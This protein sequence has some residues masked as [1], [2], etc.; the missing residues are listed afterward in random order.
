[1]ADPIIKSYF[2]KSYFYTSSNI[3]DA[4]PIYLNTNYGGIELIL[5]SNQSG[6]DNNYVDNINIS[7]NNNSL[8]IS[9]YKF[10][11]TKL[12]IIDLMGHLLY[13][14]NHDFINP[15]I[16]DIENIPNS[17]L[18]YLILENYDGQIETYS[19]ILSK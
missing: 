17:F 13:Q 14:T 6:L 1:M 10:S 7:H 18:L 2:N 5:N 16:I 3:Y 12:F 9:T 8:Q 11:K 19:K 4:L 15:F